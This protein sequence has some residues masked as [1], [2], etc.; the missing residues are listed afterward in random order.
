MRVPERIRNTR[1]NGAGEEVM[2]VVGT[3]RCSLSLF[4]PSRGDT[5]SRSSGRSVG[6]FGRLPSRE[7]GRPRLPVTAICKNKTSLF[8]YCHPV[9]LSPCHILLIP[10]VPDATRSQPQSEAPRSASV[11]CQSNPA[12][13]PTPNFP[14][15]PPSLP[16][17]PPFRA[18]I[19]DPTVD[20]NSALSYHP[21]GSVDSSFVRLSRMIAAADSRGRSSPHPAS[22]C[23]AAN[24]L[25]S[26]RPQ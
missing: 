2:V 25:V 16:S 24:P 21:L 14:T 22:R 20:P 23:V 9:T 6:R 5:E 26:P 11:D 10:A 1:G 3:S 8:R 13:F 15:S 12:V 17:L 7:L 19:T 18:Q 4:V